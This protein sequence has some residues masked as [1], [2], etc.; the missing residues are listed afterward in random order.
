[1]VL[2]DQKFIF[3]PGTPNRD[4]N[5]LDRAQQLRQFSDRAARTA[6][7][8]AAGGS[9]G[10]KKLSEALIAAANQMES[11]TPQLVHAGRIRMNYPENKVLH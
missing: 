3:L 5:F 9:G 11:L 4:V 10:N 8:V 6:R 7:M 1:V 2:N